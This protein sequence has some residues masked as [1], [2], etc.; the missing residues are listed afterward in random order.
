MSK[1]TCQYEAVLGDQTA[2]GQVTRS[3]AL[4]NVL[5]SVDELITM[6]FGKASPDSV[7]LIISKVLDN[8]EVA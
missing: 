6:D 1:Y 8:V 4:S 3:G 5:Q 2:Y 7:T